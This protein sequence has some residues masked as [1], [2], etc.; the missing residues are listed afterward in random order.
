[1][2]HN[3]VVPLILGLGLFAA[4]CG[5]SSQAPSG[6][7]TTAPAAQATT[8]PAAAKPT[9]APAPNPTTVA[10]AP[11]PT[12]AAAPAPTIAAAA[13]AAGK[14]VKG[15]TLTIATQR[16]A[17]T[18]DPTKSQDVYSNDILSLVCD[19]LFEVYD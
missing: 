3:A 10:A 16:D 2:K 8:A 15:G 14:P 5:P 17:T 6:A 12:Q 18:F 13:S 4:A 1:M 9:T 7:A 19:T 11:A